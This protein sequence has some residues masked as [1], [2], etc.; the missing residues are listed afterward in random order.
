MGKGGGE[1]PKQ[2][3]KPTKF[4]WALPD[5]ARDPLGAEMLPVPQAGR[6]LHERS[7]AFSRVSRTTRFSA[8]LVSLH[9]IHFLVTGV[10][11]A[12]PDRC[13]NTSGPTVQI[14]VRL[15]E[16]KLSATS[17]LRD[18]SLQRLGLARV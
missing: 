4:S 11:S 3:A 14:G 12:E 1:R 16:I 17:P 5:L 10:G 13:G 9:V 6:G 8:R 2:R 15:H 18:I 7:G